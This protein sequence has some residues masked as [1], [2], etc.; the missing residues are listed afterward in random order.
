MGEAVSGA[1][2][3]VRPVE[4][5]VGMPMEPRMFLAPAVC[6]AGWC[7]MADFVPAFQG[8][9]VCPACRDARNLAMKRRAVAV[10]RAM[11]T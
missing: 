10:R 7:G 4:R 2:V 11:A 6:E 3:W 1:M 8:D 9:R 5:G